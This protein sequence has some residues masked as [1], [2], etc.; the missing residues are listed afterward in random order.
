MVGTGSPDSD[1]FVWA[2]RW[3]PWAIGHGA[4]PLLSHVVWAPTGYNV[5][6][7]TTV[8]V[9]AIVVSPVTLAFGPVVAFDVLSL[10]A[11]ALAA[12]TAYLLCMR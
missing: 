2:L 5:A 9:A 12:W 7:T 10:V 3:W 8:P 4:N 1:V 6:W 11:P